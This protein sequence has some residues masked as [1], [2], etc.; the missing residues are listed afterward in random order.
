NRPIGKEVSIEKKMILVIEISHS[1]GIKTHAKRVSMNVVNNHINEC[2]CCREYS[3]N[4]N[5][6]GTDSLNRCARNTLFSAPS[7]A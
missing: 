6:N 2:F 5:E 1:N 4:N 7:L 3:L